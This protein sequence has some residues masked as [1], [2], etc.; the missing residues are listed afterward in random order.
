MPVLDLGVP[1]HVQRD[2]FALQDEDRG[3]GTPPRRGRPGTP[4]PR[5]DVRAA[6]A[7]AVAVPTA[8]AAGQ[9][10]GFAA[11]CVFGARFLQRGEARG[12][13]LRERDFDLAD[14]RFPGPRTWPE[15][16][17]TSRLA[18][19]RLKVPFACVVGL[20]RRFELQAVAAGGLVVARDVDRRCPA[21]R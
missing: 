17:L 5:A 19:L 6:G 2:A 16:I 4:G 15:A 9:P 21:R 18:P 3:R 20:E 10:A 7:I 13:D 11:N 1:G 14:V 12:Q 8:L